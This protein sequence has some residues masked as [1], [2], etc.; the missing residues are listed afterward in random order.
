MRPLSRL[1][2]RWPNVPLAGGVL[3]LLLLLAGLGIVYMSAAT[4]SAQKQ[5]E[6]EVQ[7]QILAASVTAALDFGDVRFDQFKL[8]Y[9]SIIN[10]AGTALQIRGASIAPITAQT[11]EFTIQRC[12]KN[13]IQI[14]CP[15]MAASSARY[16]AKYAAARGNNGKAKRISP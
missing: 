6:T 9:V 12:L 16:G 10:N 7:A 1:A 15:T 3:A 11:G 2:D 14:A 8:M 4:Y 5:Q 13:N